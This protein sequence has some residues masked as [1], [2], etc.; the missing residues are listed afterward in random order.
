MAQNF[1][2]TGR[3]YVHGGAVPFPAYRCKATAQERPGHTHLCRH[4][5]DHAHP[6][7][8]CICGQEWEP[9]AV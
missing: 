1:A 9:V 3:T 5:M 8:G 4:A 6:V 7:H 2:A